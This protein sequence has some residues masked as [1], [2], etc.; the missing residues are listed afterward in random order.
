MA[1]TFRGSTFLLE[2]MNT[3]HVGPNLNLAPDANPSDGLFDVVRVLKGEQPRL[4]AYLFSYLDGQRGEPS[5]RVERGQRQS[6]RGNLMFTSTIRVGPVRR[7]LFLVR[8]ALSRSR[9]TI[10]LLSFSCRE[11]RVHVQADVSVRKRPTKA[12]LQATAQAGHATG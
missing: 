1:T 3:R 4:E 10:M 6:T 12:V 9:L 2:A 11:G 7:D 5:L 8:Q